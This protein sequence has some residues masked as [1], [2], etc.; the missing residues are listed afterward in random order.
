MNE[1]FKIRVSKR[2]GKKY[3][4][5]GFLDS[6]YQL[7]LKLDTLGIKF[8]TDTKKSFTDLLIRI[9]YFTKERFLLWD[10]STAK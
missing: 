1:I 7:P 4:N 9:I 6:F 3:V 5:V 2:I 10:F 8:N